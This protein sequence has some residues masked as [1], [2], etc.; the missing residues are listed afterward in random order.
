MIARDTFDAVV[1]GEPF[2]DERVVGVQQLEDVAVLADHAAEHEFGF[3]LERL[4]QVVVELAAF[5]LRGGELPQMQPLGREVVDQRARLRVREHSFHLALDF[6]G[7]AQPLLGGRLQQLII[8][9]AA[10]DEE[11]E[12]RG[13]IDVADPESLAGRQASRGSRS[14]RYRKRGSIRM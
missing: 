4:A 6:A 9:H 8:G 1:A 11:G 14:K 7:L 2:V 10:P 13:E 5:G 3:L 12:T